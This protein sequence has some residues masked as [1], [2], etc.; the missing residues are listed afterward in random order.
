MQARVLRTIDKCGGLD[1]YLLGDKPG[2]IKE[3]GVKGWRLRWLVMRT[4]KVKRRVK[5]EKEAL[6]LVGQGTAIDEG[7]AG[8]ADTLEEEVERASGEVVEYIGG[9]EAGQDEPSELEDEPGY[10]IN[11]VDSPLSS[12]PIT[13]ETRIILL[14]LALKAETAHQAQKNT[15]ST[16]GER[17][18]WRAAQAMRKLNLDSTSHTAVEGE[19]EEL[20]GK[21]VDEVEE[22]V[23]AKMEDAKGE[24]RE[25][26]EI[27]M[28]KLRRARM[29]LEGV[30]AEAVDI[31]GDGEGEERG[32]SEGGLL[33]RIKRLFRRG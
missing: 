20:L 31:K 17:R 19:E 6:G 24:G 8:R 14:T 12:N 30:R 18:T 15:R 29:E 5:G 11:S 26:L 27:A 28:E 32:G 3:L 21:Q 13:L 4:G 25:K 16:E 9:A 7:E 22:A 2:R 1:A 23:K 10:V 33:G